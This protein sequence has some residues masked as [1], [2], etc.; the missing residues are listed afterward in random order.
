MRMAGELNHPLIGTA[1]TAV[2]SW[3]SVQRRPVKFATGGAGSSPAISPRMTSSPESRSHTS[4]DRTSP[5]TG[6]RYGSG[7]S[8]GGGDTTSS[9]AGGSGTGVIGW[10]GKHLVVP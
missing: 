3:T 4:W 1:S 7:V 9:D 5:T 6:L 2:P 8:N 10:N